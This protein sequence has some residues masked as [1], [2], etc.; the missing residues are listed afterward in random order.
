MAFDPKKPLTFQ[1]PDGECNVMTYEYFVAFMEEFLSPIYAAEVA[2]GD[3][4]T[5]IENRINEWLA[6]QREEE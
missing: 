1:L 2:K 5:Q 4:L 6:E 3:Y